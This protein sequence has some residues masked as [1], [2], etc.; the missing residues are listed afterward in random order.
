MILIKKLLKIKSRQEI[1]VDL[2]ENK[3]NYHHGV[4]AIMELAH[5]NP[6]IIGVF[7]RFTRK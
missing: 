7:W 1:L 5:D 2:V 4:K 3:S 6:D